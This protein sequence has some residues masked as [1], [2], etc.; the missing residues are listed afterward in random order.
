MAVLIENEREYELDFDCQTVAEEV[1]ARVLELERCPY[2]AEINLILTDDEEIRSTNHN[3]RGIDKETDVLS[4]P[5]VDFT[6][7]ANYDILENGFEIFFNPDTK[8]LMLGDIMISVPRAK[9]QAE[10]FGHDLKR[11]Y[12]FLI[13]H[14]I[15][16][17]LGYDHMSEE[18]AKVMELKQETALQDLNITR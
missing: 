16:H 14:S 4:F 15:L 8:A 6:N 1:A 17:L 7:P 13:A 9:E 5:M 12:A 18:E 11:E 3:F 10:Q 2:E